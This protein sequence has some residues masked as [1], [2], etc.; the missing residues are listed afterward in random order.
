MSERARSAYEEWSAADAKAREAEVTLARS[1]R[2]YFD[3]RGT[4]PDDELIDEV[5]RLRAAA[6]ERLSA[7]MDAIDAGTRRAGDKPR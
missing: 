3:G 1:W 7:A 5:S 2:A 6:N 4:P